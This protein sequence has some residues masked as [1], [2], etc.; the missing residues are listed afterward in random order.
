MHICLLYDISDL[1]LF[2]YR[3]KTNEREKNKR[4]DITFKIER[5]YH[6]IA[7]I[8]TVNARPLAFFYSF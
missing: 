7:I 8:N 3:N 2:L 1:Q 5:R 4:L 6:K